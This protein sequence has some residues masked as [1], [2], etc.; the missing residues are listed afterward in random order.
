M[1][2]SKK[3]A[4]KIFRS[5]IF[6]GVDIARS[7]E[8]FERGCCRAVDFEDGEVILSQSEESHKAGMILSGEATATTTD[9]AKNALLRFFQAGDLFGIANLFTNEDYVSSIRAKKRCRVFFFTED[10]IRELLETDKTFLYNYL[11]FLS[12]RICYLNRKI[13]YLTAGTAERRLAL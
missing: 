13:R 6:A 4:E 12:G 9:D 1:N 2:L 8:L 10:A 5:P 7:L 11:A 3:E